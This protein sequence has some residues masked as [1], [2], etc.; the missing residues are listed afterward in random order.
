MTRAA[1]IITDPEFDA[2]LIE[3]V[4]SLVN[5]KARGDALRV[6][7]ELH[8]ADV[9]RLVSQL[10]RDEAHVLFDWLP[11]ETGAEVLTE[12]DDSLNAELLEEV[13]RARIT[14]L[15]DELDTDDAADVLACLDDDVIE[16]VLPMLEDADDIQKLLTYDEETAGGIMGTE[17]VAVPPV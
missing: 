2:Q 14:A 16:Q 6:I 3:V 1:A 11:A 4:S 7:A 13:A 17:L 8:P 12:L 5:A 9:A 10:P 15:I